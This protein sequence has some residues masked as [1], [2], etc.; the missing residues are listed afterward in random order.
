MTKETDNQEKTEPTLSGS[1]KPF[2]DGLQ[3]SLLGKIERKPKLDRRD[4]LLSAIATFNKNNRR[5]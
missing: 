2:D 3:E 5:K 4:N 1:Q